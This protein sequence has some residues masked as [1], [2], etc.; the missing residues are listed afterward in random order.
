MSTSDSRIAI[1][2][3]SADGMGKSIAL[4]LASDGCNIV[5]NDLP[6]QAEALK[7][8]VRE[9]EATGRRATFVIG[10][11]SV[12]EDIRRLVEHAVSTFGGLDI[13]RC[14]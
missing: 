12:E 3:G 9:V 13:V 2:T 4:K 1:V 14:F 7:G 10:D 11:V 5:L 6:H 8:V